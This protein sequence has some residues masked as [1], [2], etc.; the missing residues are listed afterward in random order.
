M[1]LDRNNRVPGMGVAQILFVDSGQG[2]TGQVAINDRIP[3]ITGGSEAGDESIR[4]AIDV[5]ADI[6]IV[7]VVDTHELI[8]R[9]ERHRNG[10]KGNLNELHGRAASITS[11]RGDGK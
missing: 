3:P 11:R 5:E 9:G 2:R 8:G 10:G 1:R 4:N 7:L 6:E